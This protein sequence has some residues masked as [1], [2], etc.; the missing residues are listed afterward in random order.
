MSQ[1][2]YK[3]YICG[4]IFGSPEN[5]I[6]HLKRKNGHAASKRNLKYKCGQENCS[7]TFGIALSFLRHL[8]KVHSDQEP[9][10][11]LSNNFE[12]D[13]V[14]VENVIMNHAIIEP[15]FE[16]YHNVENG[17][18]NNLLSNPP[19]SQQKNSSCKLDS[20]DM[21]EL[22]NRFAT[23]LHSRPD[24]NRQM[25]FE[26]L[27]DIEKKLLNPILN[28]MC[29][30]LDDIL[31]DRDKLPIMNYINRISNIFKYVSTEHKF[32]NFLREN[33][34]FEEPK[35]IIID[36]QAVPVVRQPETIFEEIE[37]SNIYIPL[38][39]RLIKI[40][41]QGN[42]FEVIS[43][44]IKRKMLQ[45][46][47]QKMHFLNSPFWKEKASKHPD[48]ICIPWFLYNDDLGITNALGSHNTDQSLSAFYIT[49]PCL[50]RF[51]M[52]K[53]ENIALIM[54]TYTQTRKTYTNDEVLHHLIQEIN[55]LSDDVIDIKSNKIIFIFCGLLGDNASLNQNLDYTQSFNANH[56]CR[57]CLMSKKDTHFSIHENILLLRNREN[58]NNG[59]LLNDL[60]KTGIR[61][62]SIFNQIKNFHVTENLFVDAMHDLLE[63]VVHEGLS[64]FLLHSIDQKY[65]TLEQFNNWR[66]YFDY[67]S[68]A[69]RNMGRTICIEHL[70]NHK[71]KMSASEILTFTEN[72]P[73]II[74]NDVPPGYLWNY[75]LSIV[76][77]CNYVLK[78]ELTP[79][80]IENIEMLISS[81]LQLYTSLFESHLTPKMHFLTH[82][83][84]IIKKYGP[85]RGYW[86]MR[87]EAYHKLIK[88]IA[89]T[90]SSRKNLAY[91][92][93]V[94]ECLM[95]CYN[96]LINKGISMQM[97][98]P[99]R[100]SYVCFKDLAE[101][102][103][104]ISIIQI[105]EDTI[106]YESTSVLLGNYKITRNMV[107]IEESSA[108]TIPYNFHKILHIITFNH[109]TTFLCEKIVSPLYD[110]HMDAYVF[111]DEINETTKQFSIL[112]DFQINYPPSKI[113]HLRSGRNA[114]RVIF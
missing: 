61:T 21:I 101:S 55:E 17:N 108:Q 80:D 9:I 111:E 2:I 1:N 38:K 68:N 97:L 95:T 13:T 82:Y 53:L 71:F 48:K 87:L 74:E 84:R 63:G 14:S 19:S 86:T 59:I 77:L 73:L 26:L 93:A 109:V 22:G 37:I 110:P 54:L 114:T 41:E 106:V 6:N 10:S 57:L 89:N 5:L 23:Y 94:K 52:A 32:F 11:E 88:K 31:N 8:K 36:K 16:I 105:S 27:D 69:L 81:N 104:F 66:S 83:V 40:I 7:R 18:A 91:T 64:R 39:S 72:L 47:Q 24:Y 70:K 35:K 67:D 3:C 28:L 4:N 107:I 12:T 58:Y 75:V 43:N 62:E 60:S 90:T 65:F 49:L 50:P 76:K 20:I 51:L 30:K 29:E 15:A 46:S 100:G 102:E 78:Y 112:Q 44:F 45:S 92:I 85:L 99:L 42:N 96:E 56:F 113:H 98:Q 33:C 103:Y 34:Q 25:V 79:S